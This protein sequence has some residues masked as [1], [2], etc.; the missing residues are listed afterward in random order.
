MSTHNLCSEQIF[1]K[2]QSF[3]SE[4]FQFLEVK[5]FL[6]LY[7]SVSVIE[8]PIYRPKS[9]LNIPYTLYRNT[10][11]IFCYG[12]L[13]SSANHG[14]AFRFMFSLFCCML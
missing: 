10:N 14:Y 9:T 3:L 12:L 6:Y 13:C 5:V 7:R 4:S 11:Y 8:G 1:E 2:Y